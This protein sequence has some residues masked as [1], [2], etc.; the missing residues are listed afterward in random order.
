MLYLS[1][2]FS[3]IIAG[4]I[5]G[6]S[7]FGAGIV[8]M[9][10]VPFF[11]SLLSSAAI[12]NV[13]GLV[14]N[15]LMVYRYRHHIQK[16]HILIPSLFFII[17]STLSI[18]G[19]TYI[20]LSYLKILFGLFLIILA[21]YFYFFSEKTKIQANLLTMFLCG[22]ISGVCDGLF[23]VGGPLMVL[24]FLALTTRKEDY[25]G[26]IS[27]FFFIVCTFNLG[28]RIYRGLL[29]IDLLPYSLCA[30]LFVLI[31]LF[32]GNKIVDRVND[33]KL[34]QITYLLIGISGML[35]FVT[36]LLS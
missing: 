18:Y 14:L 10:V 7:G 27:T 30:V 34:K 16:E 35:T 15:I 32:L 5:Q 21:I 2:I 4:V 23:G 11:L 3:C 33:Q 17:G 19:S 25:L 9:S 12:S 29:T 31:G 13:M 28:L 22:F 1:I 20:D 24:F 6:V 36:S 26:T 8:F